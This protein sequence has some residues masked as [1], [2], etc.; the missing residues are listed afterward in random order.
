[1]VNKMG[2]ENMKPKF[3]VICGRQTKFT[4]KKIKINICGDCRHAF[5]AGYRSAYKKF[6][7]NPKYN[8]NKVNDDE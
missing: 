3:C 5:E 2:I 8:K 1:M 6:V 4:N 7:H